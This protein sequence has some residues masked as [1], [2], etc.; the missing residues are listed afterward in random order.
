MMIKP[1][2]NCAWIK[3]GLIAVIL[4]AIFLR[5]YLYWMGGTYIPV[6][7]DEALT[8][9]QALDIRNGEFPLLLSAQPY[10]FPIEAYWMTPFVNI[11]PRTALGMRALILVEGIIFLCLSLLVLRRMGTW[12]EVWPGVVLVFF[13]SVYLVMNQTAYSLPH[14][15]SAHILFLAAAWFVLKLN[16]PPEKYDVLL[17]LAGGFFAVL[18]FSNAMLSLALV[19]PLFVLAAWHS[20]GRGYWKRLFGYAAGGVIGIS[21]YALAIYTIPGSHQSV[22]ATHSLADTLERLWS[23]TIKVTLPVTFG[24]QPTLFPDQHERL[25]WGEWGTILF[26]YFFIALI[27]IAV[28]IGFLQI[29]KK[30]KKGERTYLGGLEMALGA[31]VLCCLL[32]MM[33]KRADSGAY[34]YLL[35]VVVVFPFLVTGI[36]IRLPGRLRKIAISMVLILSAYN[37][38]V[39]IRLPH[40]WKHHAFAAEVVATPD[41]KPVMDFLRANGIYHCYASHWAAYRITFESLGDITCSQPYNER[42]GNWP[43]PNKD[44]VNAATNAA[45]VLSD[46]IRFLK[47]GIFERHM[48]IMNVVSQVETAGHFNVYYNFSAPSYDPAYRISPDSITITAA[49]AMDS[50]SRIMDGSTETFWRSEKQQHTNLWIQFD[51]AEPVESPHMVLKYGK[52]AHDRAP[53][54]VIRLLTS[55]GWETLVDNYRPGMDKFAWFNGKPVYDHPQQTFYLGTSTVQAISIGIVEANPEFCWTIAEAEIYS[56]PK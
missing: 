22:T 35:P 44:E 13:P 23:P 10:M 40:E 56:A 15:S 50:I 8:V 17:A 5:L 7:T 21:P 20:I 45:Y 11:L 18:A 39:S 24:W 6:T 26:P 9:L 42:F 51:L 43:V 46:K 38:A 12:R 27:L 33:G 3:A 49:E 4:A 55:N 47:P 28:L 25:N 1:K 2:L 31:S 48:R 16:R 54:I 41:L 19:T 32:F 52:F 37:I 29:V 36:L 53:V 14:N 30:W 34:R